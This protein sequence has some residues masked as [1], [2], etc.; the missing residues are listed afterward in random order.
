M[1]GAGRPGAAGRP[2]RRRDGAAL[3]GR[4]APAPAAAPAANAARA[5]AVRAAAGGLSGACTPRGSAQAQASPPPVRGSSCARALCSALGSNPYPTLAL[6]DRREPRPAGRRRRRRTRRRW[7]ARRRPR[8]ARRWSTWARSAGPR[9][10]PRCACCST[11]RSPTGA[12][13]AAPTP[14]LPLPC[15]ARAS[16]RCPR[17]ALRALLATA[18]SGWCGAVHHHVWRAQVQRQPARSSARAP[19]AARRGRA[20][21]GRQ[22]AY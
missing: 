5:N 15:P 17:A 21:S 12:G 19:R 4:A 13:A 22:R 11:R 9:S 20:R 8:S 14:P 1:R 7:R 2:S 6:S 10:R 16:E 3:A 18:Q